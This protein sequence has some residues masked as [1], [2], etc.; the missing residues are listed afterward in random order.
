MR[1]FVSYNSS[2]YTPPTIMFGV[3]PSSTNP[4]PLTQYFIHATR[5]AWKD[6]VEHE[7]V[8]LLGRGTLPKENFIKFIK[9]MSTKYSPSFSFANAISFLH[10]CPRQDYHYLKYYAR[11]YA[12]VVSYRFSPRGLIWCFIRLLAAKSDT[13]TKIDTATKTILGVLREIGTHRMFC[14]KFG[15]TGI[16]LET[17][18]EEL[19]T[20]AY[21]CYLMDV[22]LQGSTF[23]GFPT[24]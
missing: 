13:F 18:P 7:F 2:S 22:G 14:A 12:Y 23:F 5:K 4:Y 16:E 19:A 8:V 20:T 15:V 6:Y 1:A 3:R 11:A 9:C 17:T 21:G 24:A 10:H